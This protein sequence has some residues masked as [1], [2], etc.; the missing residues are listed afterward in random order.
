MASMAKNKLNYIMKVVP[1]LKAI[2]NIP[3]MMVNS[4]VSTIRVPMK[5]SN[6]KVI[7]FLHLPQFQKLLLVLLNMSMRNVRPMVKRPYSMI[8]VSVLIT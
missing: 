4:I 5:V 1:M 7:I 8:V 2:T 6:L 3:V